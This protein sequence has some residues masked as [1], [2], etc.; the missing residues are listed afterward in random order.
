MMN[1]IKNKPIKLDQIML[2]KINNQML[3]LKKDKSKR[4]N[5]LIYISSL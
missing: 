4:Q 1:H 2:N 3:S 5:N